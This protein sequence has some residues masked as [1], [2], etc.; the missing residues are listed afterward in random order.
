MNSHTARR[1]AALAALFLF[2][3]TP[4]ARAQ[5]L[6]DVSFAGV[7]AD[8]HGARIP[9]A[10][11]TATHEGTATARAVKADDE[12][13]YRLVELPPG[14]Y[15]LRAESGGF[16]AAVR[17][18]VTAVAGRSERVD[19]VLVPAGVAAAQVVVDEAGGALVDTTRTVAGGTLTREELERLPSSGRSA[20]DFVFTLGGVTEEPLSTRDAADDRAAAGGA[21]VS[22]AAQTPEE[23]GSFALAGGAAYSNNITIDGLDNN[24]D[25]AARERFLPSIEAVEEVQVITSQFS[26]EYGRASGGRV[27]L[28]TRGGSRR[29]RGRLFHFFRDEALDANTWNNNRRG[30]KRLPF[31]EHVAGFTLSGP[32]ARP[33]ARES[34][35]RGRRGGHFFFVAYEY[36]TVLDTTLI[37][38]LVPVGQNPAFPL[39]APTTLVGRRFEPAA[40]PPNAPAE[41][42]PF[43]ERVS[44]PLRNHS[45]V[46]RFDLRFGETHNGTLT[47]QLGRAKDLRQTGGGLRLAGGLQGRERNTEA[48]SYADNLV[49]SEQTVN[50]FRAQVSRLNPSVRSRAGAS[51][52]VV[53]VAINDPLDAADPLDRSGTLVAGASTGGSTARSETRFQLQETLTLVRGRHTFKVGADLQRVRSTFFDLTDT[54]G[55]YN[56]TSAGDFLAS[57]PARFRQR[58][59]T[60]SA[61]R[62]LYAG[63]FAQNEWRAR[64]NLTVNL[65]LRYERETVLGDYDNFGPRLGLALDPLGTGRVVL[66]AGAGVFYNRALLRTIDD[67]TLA[68]GSVEFDTNRLPEAA[69][70]PFIAANLRFPTT[71]APDSPLVREL[72]TRQTDFA[73]RLDPALKIPESYQLH[74]AFEGEL[75]G[76]L[77]FEAG[78]TFNRG[79]HLWRE[80]NANAPRLPA[81]FRD[82]AEYLSSRDFA[83]FRDGA[84][85]RPIYDAS[86]AGDLARFAPLHAGAP[87]VSRA[88]EFGVPVTL[89]DLNSVNSS[90]VLEA[91]LAALRALRPD[92]ARTQLEQ[93]SSIGNS[94]YH[95]LVLETRRRFTRRAGGFGGSLRAAYTLSRLIDDGVVNTSSALVAGDFRRERARSLLD[96]R[97]RLAVSGALDLPRSLGGWQL[98]GLLRAGSGAP[99]N[100]TLGGAD[101]NLDDVSN[102]R[103]SFSGDSKLIRWRRPGEPLDARLVAALS[104]PAI[105]QTGNLP[106]NAG[107]GPPTFAF[108]MKLA[109]E[110][111]RGERLRLRPSVE[112]DSALNAAVFTFGA[113]FINFSALRAD[114]TP[115]QRRAFLDTFLVPTRT[116]RP[117]TLRL[118]V[119][120]DF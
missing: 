75:A 50:Q 25:R 42:A 33:R 115:E 94:F 27:N 111:R 15:E 54:A 47:A 61:Q 66:R 41:L 82:F 107:H 79:L 31:Q 105:G 52:P 85:A 34:S 16:A 77:V 59:N 7:V 30:L 98:S 58:F 83:N 36:R 96:R 19:F 13:R 46:T 51:G 45:L 49:L 93:V 43:I 99:F 11:V 5:D 116:L 23:A 73:R 3:P 38:A 8:H 62:N 70:R 35:G 119:R 117:R 28:R 95:G 2:L 80:V 24:D 40:T 53:L 32:L 110:F 4:T 108:D 39:P 113:E 65:G 10:T 57:A 14:V 92:P 6:D 86:T 114:A 69:R 56:F 102:D 9:G 55:T 71:L 29:Y 112:I 91:A 44:T 78:Y 68:G 76:R 60:S 84:G 72:G 81:G 48:L 37:D 101:R 1:A 17:T 120:L 104:L 20:L 21:I 118:G 74:A 67:F 26:A 12:G 106:R 103:P 100:L 63:L 87:A 109:R 18:G 90:T 88:I 97:H 64:A 22:R 89:F